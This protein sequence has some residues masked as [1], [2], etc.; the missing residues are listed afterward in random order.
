MGGGT[1]LRARTYASAWSVP[2]QQPLSHPPAGLPPHTRPRNKAG[3][4]RILS[5]QE[6][7]E[8]GE[9]EAVTANVYRP[10]A[11]HLLKTRKVERWQGLLP[12]CRA[13]SIRSS[14]TRLEHLCARGQRGDQGASSGRTRRGRWHA[15]V[16]RRKGRGGP[17]QATPA[18]VRRV[19]R[20][21][22]H[23]ASSQRATQSQQFLPHHS[24]HARCWAYLPRP[25]RCSTLA[26][27]WAARRA[28]SPNLP[29]NSDGGIYSC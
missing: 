22:F 23:R 27:R 3:V 29:Q 25:R 8:A 15:N 28:T 12:A 2:T 5:K 18:P 19:R 11:Q 26:E 14:T 10:Q 24:P 21:P 13:T 6:E 9:A 17:H 4:A 16:R 1:V 7:D 20:E